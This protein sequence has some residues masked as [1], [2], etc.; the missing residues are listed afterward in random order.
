MIQINLL[1]DVKRELIHAQRVRATVISFSMIAC[2]VA[3]VLVGVI[4][5]W[6]GIQ[7]GR[8]FRA[9]AV[10]TEQSKKFGE[11]KDVQH[12]LTVQ[13]QLAKISTYN[14]KKSVTS[15]MF[16]VASAINPDAPNSIS[17]VNMTVDTSTKTLLLECQAKGG[18]A[19]LEVFKKTILATKLYAPNDTNGVALATDLNDADRS[20][21]DGQ[22]GSRVLRF[23]LSFKYPDVLFSNTNDS[24]KIVAP[25]KSNA[26]DSY[27]G[28]PFTLFADGVTKPRGN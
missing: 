16:D 7:V 5:L 9:N 8:E 13:N 11:V 6:M 12:T 1:P 24:L 18:Y 20:L 23:M 21:G 17:I 19:A 10:I 2:I 26:T 27:V 4:L 15:R 25:T 3:A 28:V 22:D 14:D